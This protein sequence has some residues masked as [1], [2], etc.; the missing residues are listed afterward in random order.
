MECKYDY[1]ID[2][3]QDYFN[4]LCDMVHIDQIERTYWLL[5]KDMYRKEFIVYIKHDD[6][7]ASDGIE[8][9]EDF[10]RETN[11]NGYLDMDRECSVLEMM[12][13]LA[14]RMDFETSDPNDPTCLTDNTPYWF[15]EMIE[16]LGLI[17]FDDSSYVE[18]E[19]HTYVD[20]ILEG[21]VNRE[22][23]ASGDGGLF[24]LKGVCEDQREVEIWYQ[25]CA[26]LMEHYEV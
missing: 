23:S 26:Y 7:R 19:G 12:I 8:L 1:S 3:E 20:W 11:Y 22:Y 9:R 18:L 17:D 13:A 10:M 15:W 25:M 4:W 16:N 5:A 14:R 21:L 24:P 2:V 6:N